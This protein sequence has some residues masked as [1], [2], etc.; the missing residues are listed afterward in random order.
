MLEDRVRAKRSI[1]KEQTKDQ[2]MH[3]QPVYIQNIQNSI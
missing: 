3:K 1:L 2:N